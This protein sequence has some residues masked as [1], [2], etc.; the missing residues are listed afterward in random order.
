MFYTHIASLEEHKAK[1]SK[2]DLSGSEQRDFR[3]PVLTEW[4]AVEETGKKNT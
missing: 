1:Y 3:I 2:W 4:I